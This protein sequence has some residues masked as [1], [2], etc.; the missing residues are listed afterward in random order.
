MTWL[1]LLL[2]ALAV[3]FLEELYR[4]VFCRTPSRLFTLLFDSK[5]HEPRYYQVRDE[6]ARRLGCLPH[7][8]YTIVNDRGQAL[9]GF[10]YPCG[11]EGKRLVFLI[12]GYR[13]DHLDTGGLYYDYYKSRGIDFFCC[14]HTACGESEGT[15]I[16]F[17]VLESRDC[18]LWL[19]FLLETFGPE[20]QIILHGFSMGGAT[21]LQMSSRC[22]PQVKFIVSDSGFSSARAAMQHQIGPLY[23]PLRLINLV[24]ARYDWD[25]SD[26]TRSLSESQLP[27]LFV[28]GREDKLVPAYIGPQLY[29]LYQGEKDG[30]FPEH[31]RHIES[32]YT[33]PVEYASRLDRF[34]DRFLS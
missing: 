14:D 8:C 1:L 24:L 4:Y 15:H 5:G 30:F 17:D 2:P 29:A 22:P 11:S 6:A 16:G 28:H 7:R 13:S 32:M 27:I 12:H 34:M 33:S 26:V 20:V 25:Q 21:V 31:T 10:Y 3:L 19:D 9:K 18:L 23:Q